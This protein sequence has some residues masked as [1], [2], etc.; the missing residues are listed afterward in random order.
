MTDVGRIALIGG[1]IA[2]AS[3]AEELRRQGFDGAI[4]LLTRELDAPYHRPPITKALLSDPAH[5]VQFASPDWWSDHDI[6][7]RTR[8]AVS[9]LD[10]GAH[11]VTL[12][13]KQ[14]LDYDKALIATGATVR[15]LAIEG[16]ALPGIHYL[17]TPANAHKLREEAA[18]AE[19]IVLVGGS[20][21][22]VEVAASMTAQGRQCTL[23]MQENLCLER[24]F[25]PT[26]GTFVDELLR[27]RGVEIIS[28]SDV[29]AFMGT[30]ALSGVRTAG[31]A[32]IPCDLAVVGVGAVPDAKLASKAGLQIGESGGVRCD[33]QLRTSHPD[34]YAA[35]DVCEYYSVAHGR[36]LRVEH[37]RHA[38]AQG[39]T[40]AQNMIG[41][42]RDHVD[43]PYFW[44]DIADWARLEYVGAAR[45]WD[46]E[47]VTG[48]PEDGAFTVWYFDGGRLV[49][50]L[51]NGR[52][53]DL[54]LARS[55]LTAGPDDKFC[56]RTLIGQTG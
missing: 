8:S 11:V 18:V 45:H 13:N 2:A 10:V 17:R 5:D 24:T 41:A 33:S 31:G 4:T 12:T 35:G 20:F 29:A 26:V 34:V 7:V 32:E 43:V 22:A 55:I 48:S 37:E 19:R 39:V 56:A 46:E 50:A 36:Q 1:G 49:A 27:R 3:A 54:D 23:V 28:R 15:R 42:G 6:E 53:D 44:T 21:I 14:T 30:D 16:S 40:A 38:A 52:S 9:A 47:V 51:T 25:G